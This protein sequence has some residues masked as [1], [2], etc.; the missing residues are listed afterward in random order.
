MRFTRAAHARHA[1]IRRGLLL[2]V[3]TVLARPV[4]AEDALHLD[5]V[6]EEARAHNP[7]IQAARAM[8]EA[9]AAIPAKAAALDDPTFTYETWNAPSARVDRADNN[10]FRL[11]QRLPFPGKRRLAGRVAEG[12]ADVARAEV[13]TVTLDVV[14]AVKRAYYELWRAEQDR[15]VYGRELALVQRYARLSEQR[16]AT[17]EATQPDVLQA[18]IE[19][20]R[21]EGRVATGA[22][23]VEAAVAEL[24]ALLARP[25]DTPPGTPVDEPRPALQATSESLVELALAHRPELAAQNAAVAREESAVLLAGRERYPDFEVGVARF[26]NHGQRDGFGGMVSVSIP[27]ANLRKYDAADAEARA[28]LASAEA[29]RRRLQDRIRL[30]VRQAYVRA[31][32]AAVEHDLFIRT[33]V[34]RAEQALRATETAY[35]TGKV[36]FLRL[37]ESARSIEML[38]LEH[39]DAAATFEQAFADLERA[40]GTPL[41]HG[42]RP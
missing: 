27:I 23:A 26:V 32:R 6:V 34:P 36:D 35:A 42:E 5:Q 4:H 19:V 30:E 22:L 8:G 37:V 28:R 7:E 38:H 29:T 33:H 13:E 9:A 21:L 24:N 14:A 16:Y 11:S 39:V 15:I 25:G 17:G 2:A 31:Q 10:I 12:D 41:P 18:G 1:A 3:L 20:A 40:V